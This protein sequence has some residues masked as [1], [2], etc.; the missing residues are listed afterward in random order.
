MLVI[1]FVASVFLAF[2]TILILIALFA[3][4]KYREMAKAKLLKLKEQTFFNGL[5]ES[6]KLSLF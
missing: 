2:V 1:I 6:L 5:I 3:K 4:K